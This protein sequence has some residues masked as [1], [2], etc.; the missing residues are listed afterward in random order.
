M[1][2][3][4]DRNAPAVTVLLPVR[5]GAAYLEAAIASIL[6][7]TFTNFELLVVDDGSTDA[8]QAILAGLADPRVRVLRQDPLGLVPALNRGLYEARAPLIARMDADDIAHPERLAHQEALLAAC[9]EVALVGSGWRVVAPD[10]STRRVVVP[11]ASDAGLREALGRA[12]AIAHPTVMFRRDAVIA[13][14]LYRP[15]FLLAEDYDLWFRL[16]ERHELAC[17]PEVLLDYREHAGQSAWRS[18]EQRIC[19][20]VGAQAAHRLRLSGHPDHGDD[21]APIDH[22]RLRTMGLTDPEIA[23]GLIARALGAAKDARAA[24]NREAMRAAIRLGLRQP[25][26]RLRT[27]T[28]FALLPLLA[29]SPSGRGSG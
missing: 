4:S 5:N 22:A 1:M 28:H 6:R 2:P 21:P 17:L 8:T 13:A 29:P 19:S 23:A 18:L 15:A 9:P 24:G 11:P 7:Q 14:G 16:S 27:R 25:G 12:N 3:P 20:E 26:L 10:G